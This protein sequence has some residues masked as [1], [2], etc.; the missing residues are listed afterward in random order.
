MQNDTGLSDLL[1]AIGM[2]NITL[3]RELLEKG[4]HVDPEDNKTTP[5]MAAAQKGHSDIMQLLI[6]AGANVNAQ[7]HVHGTALFYAAKEGKSEACKLLISSGALVDTISIN[8]CTPLRSAL[9]NWRTETMRVLIEHGHANVNKVSGRN[10]LEYAQL[11]KNP[12]DKERAKDPDMVQ[13]Q[14]LLELALSQNNNNATKL[15]ITSGANVNIRDKNGLT[16]LMI[17]AQKGQLEAIKLLV[18]D[19]RVDIKEKLD[20]NYSAYIFA[21]LNGHKKCKE[22][23]LSKCPDLAPITHENQN[24]V[25]GFQSMWHN[26][27]HWVATH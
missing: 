2:Q 25:T 13:E 27:H 26:I 21:A 20:N 19:G 24:A 14:T 10:P 6:K 7:D 8:G 18:E 11:Q 1:V 22:Y 17:A 9:L 12:D 15:L 3:V 5:L 23:L 16:L 4:A